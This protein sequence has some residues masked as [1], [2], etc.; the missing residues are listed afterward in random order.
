MKIEL[1][2]D[3]L[4]PYLNHLKKEIKEELLEELDKDKFLSYPRGL[5]EYLYGKVNSAT[6]QKVYVLWNTK[7]FPRNVKESLRGVYSK[8]LK[9]WQSSK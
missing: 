4:R 7:G 8:D 5:Q 1:E 6:Y 3:D 2:Y 9:N